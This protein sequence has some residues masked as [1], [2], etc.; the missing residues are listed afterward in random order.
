ML[1]GCSGLL[2]YSD[3]LRRIDGYVDDLDLGLTEQLVDTGTHFPDSVLFGGTF[4][5]FA[6][7]VGDAHDLKSNFLIGGQMRIVDDSSG[8]DNADPVVQSLR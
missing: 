2:D 7:S 6:I 8:T 4:R 1:T 5:F 3:L